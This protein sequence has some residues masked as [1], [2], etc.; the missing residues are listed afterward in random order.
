[1]SF[2]SNDTSVVTI[3]EKGRATAVGLGKTTIDVTC[4]DQ[5]LTVGY[6]VKEKVPEG[7][8]GAGTAQTFKAKIVDVADSFQPSI[9]FDSGFFTF[10]ENTYSGMGQYKGIY[11]KKDGYIYCSVTDAK[12]MEGYAGADV[13]EIVF[14]IVDEK[15]IKLKTQLCMSANGD[16]FYLL[17]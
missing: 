3:D 12:T 1:M 7:P 15:T 14:K 11:D 4:G 16:L 13:K 2:K 10:T 5:K 17:P 9:F 8:E 6:E